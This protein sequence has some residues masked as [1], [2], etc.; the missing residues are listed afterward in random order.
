VC[1]RRLQRVCL[2]II[3]HKKMKK[4]V[5]TCGGMR[6]RLLLGSKVAVLPRCLSTATSGVSNGSAMPG[7]QGKVYNS[8]LEALQGIADGSKIAFSGFGLC[9]IPENLITS[10]CKLGPK[11][12]DCVSNDAGVGDF[13][14][15][16]LLANGQVRS[17]TASFLGE[18]KTFLKVWKG[19]EVE[20]NLVPQGTLAEKLRAGG[21]GIPAFYS[22]AGV[23]TAVQEGSLPVRYCSKSGEVD[24]YSNPKE[25]RAFNGREYLLEESIIADYALIKAWK[26]D[27]AGNLVFRGTARNFNPDCAKAAKVTIVEVEELVEVGQ[28]KPDEIH[29][30][31]IYVSRIVVG[32]KY[33]KRIEKLTVRKASS[34]SA[35]TST[36]THTTSSAKETIAKRAARELKDGMY[37]NIGIGIPTLVSNYLPKGIRVE[38]HSENGLLGTGPYPLEGHADPD[39]INA[40]KETVS[41]L[42]GSSTFAS[43]ESFA[44]IRGKH[45]DITILGALEVSATGDLANWIIPGK[46]IKGMGGA[47]DLVAACGRVR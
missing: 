30:P 2:F 13:G 4:F 36:P 38:L 44:M 39:I 1:C 5:I 35:T 6:A 22:A 14:F 46:S 16:E 45:I 32:E 31:G 11:K 12:L 43:S 41:Y 47:M 8:T 9:G 21:A 20:L 42:P 25:S 23:G 15:G 19:G 10:L 33:S 18:H 24:K 34:S 26:G 37:V 29:L 17:L 3:H 27:K 28:L 40:G 7:S